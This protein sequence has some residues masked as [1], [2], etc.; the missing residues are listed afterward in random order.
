MRVCRSRS[1]RKRCSHRS[2]KSRGVGGVKHRNPKTTHALKPSRPSPGSP[3]GAVRGRWTGP[4]TGPAPPGWRCTWCCSVGQGPAW[5]S[6]SERWGGGGLAL[7]L[8]GDEVTVSHRQG[9][10]QNLDKEEVSNPPKKS[11]QIH[12]LC[13]FAAEKIGNAT[14]T[15]FRGCILWPAHH[16]DHD[17]TCTAVLPPPPQ[18]LSSSWTTLDGA[19]PADDEVVRRAQ[20]S[21]QLR[22]EGPLT[23]PLP[24]RI[25]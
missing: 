3:L 16:I 7:D 4:A 19:Q 6:W 2:P 18:P 9:H 20:P 13:S 14:L 21:L 11:F 12:F 1:A 8:E 5:S 24:G 17:R 23:G 22:G 15:P 25:W 10:S